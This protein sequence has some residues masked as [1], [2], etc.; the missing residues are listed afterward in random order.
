MARRREGRTITTQGAVHLMRETVSRVRH[1]RARGQI[2]IRSDSGFYTHTVVQVCCR[3]TDVRFSIT[4][5]LRRNLR[6]LIG[7]IPESDW[8]P[9]PCWI[10]VE[11]MSPRLNAQLSRVT[12]AAQR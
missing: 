8:R 1:A 4:V 11:P 12:P 2:T 6:I 3:K 7:V 10:E 5:R 9:I